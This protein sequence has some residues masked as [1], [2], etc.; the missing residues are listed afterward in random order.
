MA[1]INYEEFR[2]PARHL[3]FDIRPGVGRLVTGIELNVD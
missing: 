1:G 2:S 3:R